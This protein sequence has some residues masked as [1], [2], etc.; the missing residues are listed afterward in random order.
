LPL[1]GIMVSK[2]IKQAMDEV[3]PDDKWMH[4]YTYSGHPT[5]CAVGL[6]NVEIMERERLWERSAALGA[7]L[8]KALHAAFD[9]H[10]NVGDI[11]SGKGLI[12]AIE[13]VEE[14]GPTSPPN[15]HRRA[16]RG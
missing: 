13:L 14:R 12:A 8:H 4:A 5:C 16:A 2:A 10:P 3:K 6:K 7:R 1:G 9:S 15:P 11:R